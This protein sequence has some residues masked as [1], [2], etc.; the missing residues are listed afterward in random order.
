MSN[1]VHHADTRRD[2][3]SYYHWDVLAMENETKLLHSRLPGAVGAT[4]MAAVFTGSTLLRVRADEG[5]ADVAVSPHTH[6]RSALVYQILIAS[7]SRSCK[8]NLWSVVVTRDYRRHIL[9]FLDKSFHLV[10]V[11]LSFSLGQ[12]IRVSGALSASS[13]PA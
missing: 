11:R 3:F 5:F 13:V 10:S 7:F 12:L 9:V 2:S 6:S 8:N 1:R 4:L